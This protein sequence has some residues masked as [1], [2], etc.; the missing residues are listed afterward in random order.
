MKILIGLF[1][2]IG[3][4]GCSTNSNDLDGKYVKDSDG[5]VYRVVPRTGDLSILSK[6]NLEELKNVQEFANAE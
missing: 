1:L 3:L 6:I 5:N 2:I 4:V